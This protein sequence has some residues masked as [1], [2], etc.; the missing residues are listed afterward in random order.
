[1]KITDAFWEKRNLGVDV[2]EIACAASDSREELISA[3]SEVKTPYSVCKI[4]GGAAELLLCAQDQGYRVIEMSIGLEGKTRELALPFIYRRFEPEIAIR[5]AKSEQ[6]EEVL[7][8]VEAGDIFNTDRIALDP[9]F[10]KKVAGRRYANWIRDL[11]HQGAHLCIGYYKDIPAAFGVNQSKE[12]GISDAV[13]GGALS[14][15][16]GVGLGFLSIYANLVSGIQQGNTK[17]KTHVSSNNLPIIHLHRQFGFQ[18]HEMQY[19]LVK[20]Q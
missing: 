18:I 15:G 11:L 4:P 13:V 3:L 19:V 10:G 8:E 6:I 7:W 12:G 14:N 2:T 17:I 5:D 16:T 20:Y 9:H 1:M